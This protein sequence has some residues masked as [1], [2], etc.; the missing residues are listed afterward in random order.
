M[1][2]NATQQS[3]IYSPAFYQLECYSAIAASAIS[4]RK[5]QMANI[6]LHSSVALQLEQPVHERR[7]TKS[8]PGKPRDWLKSSS[9]P[10]IRPHPVTTT[11]T[12]CLR[13]PFNLLMQGTVTTF[14]T[15]VNSLAQAKRDMH[16]GTKLQKRIM[17]HGKFLVCCL[18]SVQ[19]PA[20][21]GPS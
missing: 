19:K 9:F 1:A 7:E 3:A 12:K 17:Y 20:S 2:P 10:N 11:D 6:A 5:C 8:N 4:L 16:E 13:E 21:E 15:L 18:H 14:M